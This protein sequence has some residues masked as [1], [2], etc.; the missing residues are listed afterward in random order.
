MVTED[1]RDDDTQVSKP[2]PGFLHSLSAVLWGM[3]GVRRGKTYREQDDHMNPFHVLVAVILAT[4]AFIA[5]L[6]F[7]VKL[8]TS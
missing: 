8:A 6:V 2:K 7:F 4:A 5:V 3:M 1:K